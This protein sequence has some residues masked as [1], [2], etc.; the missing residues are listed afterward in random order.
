[1]NGVEE[2][3]E[4]LLC[5]E[6]QKEI[7]QLLERKLIRPC[8]ENEP[9]SEAQKYRYFDRTYIA[10]VHWAI[11]GKCNYRCKHCFMYAPQAKFPEPTM[12]EC[13]TIIRGMQDAGVRSIAL[14]GGEP[15]VRSDFW[16][17][18]MRLLHMESKSKESI[19]MVPWSRTVF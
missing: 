14:T 9:L 8:M 10:F 7:A 2:I 5:A 16:S 12:E 17:W 13:R 15:L 3:Q 1:M 19:R 6:E 4:E 18:W 11:T